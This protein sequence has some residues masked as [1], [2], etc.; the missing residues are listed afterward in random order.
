MK[1]SES[2]NEI[3]LAL[4]LAQGEIQNPTASVDNTFFK[5]KYADLAEVLNVVRPAFSRHKLSVVQFPFT[6]ESGDIGVTTMISHA[7]GQFMEGSI[8]IPLQVAKNVA[9][10]AGEAITYLRRYSLAAAAGIA[11]EDADGNLGEKNAGGKVVNLKVISSEKVANLAALIEKTETD[12]GAF[13]QF[14]GATSLHKMPEA[15][16][17]KAFDA[18]SAKLEGMSK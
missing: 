7:S 1:H 17:Q 14:C 11:Q 3:S 16:Y 18:L 9:Q 13:L 10:D 4:A 5:S 15:K 8:T 12:P 2:I 6:S